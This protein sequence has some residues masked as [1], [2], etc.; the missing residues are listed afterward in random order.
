MFKSIRMALA[1][2]V[3]LCAVLPVQSAINTLQLGAKYDATAANIDF[4]LF[5]SRATRIELWIYKTPAGAQQL[6]RY[7]MTKNATTNVWSKTVSVATLRN[8]YGLTGTVYYGYRAWGP[9]WPY[10]SSWSKGSSI[11]FLSDVDASGNRFNPNKLLLDPYARE[12]SQDP[13]T[14][15]CLDGT[16]YASG[17][18]HRH[19]DNGTCAPKGIVLAAASGSIGTKPT[20]AFKDDIVYEVHVRGLTMNDTAVAIEPA[21]HLCRRRDQ[22]RLPRQSRHHRGRIPASAGN[23]ERDQ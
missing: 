20:R 4:K 21:R 17:A 7:V 9:N 2:L 19:K 18:S 14:P 3:L 12:I 10:N 23:P 1:L 5:S 13:N 15:T 8:S 16:I 11:G 6:V 22:G